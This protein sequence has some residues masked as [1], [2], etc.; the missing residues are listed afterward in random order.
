MRNNIIH[1]IFSLCLSAMFLLAGTGYN[2]THYCCNDCKSAGIETAARMSCESIH[3]QHCH[4]KSTTHLHDAVTD[5]CNHLLTKGC[6]IERLTVDVP[7]IQQ[8]NHEFTDYTLIV[9]DL[10]DFQIS[11]LLPEDFS[12]ENKS[13]HTPQKIPVPLP[14]RVI[15]SLKSVLII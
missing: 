5:A 9:S 8:P 4:D 12:L 14:G 11:L 13:S 7:S 15:L 6:N 1:I 2:L 10:D 3:E